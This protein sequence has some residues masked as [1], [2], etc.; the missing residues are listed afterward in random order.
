VPRKKV[1]HYETVKQYFQKAHSE[2]NWTLGIAT[3]AE[4]YWGYGKA[5][6]HLHQNRIVDIALRNAKKRDKARGFR[7]SLGNLHIRMTLGFCE[8]TS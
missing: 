5:D 6:A 7:L 8:K 3:K 1:R 4:K 2:F